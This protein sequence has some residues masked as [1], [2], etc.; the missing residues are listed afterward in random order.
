MIRHQ[1]SCE[2]YIKSLILT[3]AL[4]L[5]NNYVSASGQ[6]TPELAT[7]QYVS[8]ETIAPES[9][10]S[11]LDEIIDGT[12][13]HIINTPTLF[14]TAEPRELAKAKVVIGL[15]DQSQK[16]VIKTVA[17]A[18]AADRFAD[19]QQLSNQLDNI[20]IGNFSN[21]PSGPTANKAIIDIHNN[22]VIVIAPENIADMIVNAISRLTDTQQ[23]NDYVII[24]I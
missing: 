15:I 5:G 22:N 24:K 23:T 20:T 6:N 7:F 13:S 1:F 12:I 17:P 21:P 14:I 9:A 2:R 18:S 8:L 4:V 3:I 19:C 10:K 11:F 16:F